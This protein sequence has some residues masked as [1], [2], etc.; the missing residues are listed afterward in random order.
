MANENSEAWW[1]VRTRWLWRDRRIKVDPLAGLAKLANG[2]ADI[3]HP[4]RGY[5]KT[6]SGAV[7]RG[8]AGILVHLAGG[9]P[10][11]CPQ[12]G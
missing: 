6:Y 12:L 9:R 7:W 5:H 11:P 2:A 3:R 1:A 4:R 10:I 8:K